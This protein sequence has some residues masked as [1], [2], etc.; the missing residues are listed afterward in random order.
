MK[1][2][3]EAFEVC[4][5]IG[6]LV[7]GVSIIVLVSMGSMIISSSGC[8]W[9]IVGL[10]SSSSVKKNKLRWFAMTTREKPFV[11]FKA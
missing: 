7:L 3:D 6:R 11:A 1:F 9:L 4:S 5:P 2:S 10:C 8:C